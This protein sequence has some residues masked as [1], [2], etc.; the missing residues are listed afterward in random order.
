M[1]TG[2]HF[3]ALMDG[4]LVVVLG[5]RNGYFTVCGPWE[6][7]VHA[8]SLELLEEIPRPAGHETTRL[9]YRELDDDNA[10][11]H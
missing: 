6:C 5:G 1:T 3:W 7:D 2:K 8:D 11:A 10:N 4:E 9:V